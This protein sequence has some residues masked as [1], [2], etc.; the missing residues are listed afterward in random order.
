MLSLFKRY[1]S[2]KRI[3]FLK[4]RLNRSR[5]YEPYVD[6]AREGGVVVGHKNKTSMPTA[7]RDD[8][9]DNRTTLFLTKCRNLKN[10]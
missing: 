7:K 2:T 10:R 9:N 4:R 6:G 5:K 8:K 3:E 1:C